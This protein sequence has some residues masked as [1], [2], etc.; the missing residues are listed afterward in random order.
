MKDLLT[1]VLTTIVVFVVQQILI[2]LWDGV[3][4]R[5]GRKKK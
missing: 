2:F 3:K 1:L 4:S 5:K